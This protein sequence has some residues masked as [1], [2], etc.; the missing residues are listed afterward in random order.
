M[1]DYSII[2]STKNK[3]IENTAKNLTPKIK[4]LKYKKSP[5]LK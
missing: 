3:Y 5:K 4:N 2:D 1:F